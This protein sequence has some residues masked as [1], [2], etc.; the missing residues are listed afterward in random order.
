MG[1]LQAKRARISWAFAVAIHLIGFVGIARVARNVPM[2][3]FEN[4]PLRSEEAEIDIQWLAESPLPLPSLDRQSA[5]SARA[6][7]RSSVSPEAIGASPQIG[8]NGSTAASPNENSWSLNA[9]GDA[10]GS[11]NAP[12]S[13][14]ILPTDLLRRTAAADGVRAKDAARVDNAPIRKPDLK[15]EGISFALA[16]PLRTH[17]SSHMSDPDAPFQ[18]M[19]TL[20][21]VITRTGLSLSGVRSSTNDDEWEKWAREATKQFDT[22]SIRL[23]ER[24]DGLRVS[25]M[26]EAFERSYEGALVKDRPPTGPVLKGTGI[27]VSEKDG[28]QLAIELPSVTVGFQGKKCAGGATISAAGV[29]LGAGCDF[30]PPTRQTRVRIVEESVF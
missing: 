30:V 19:A 26:V 5:S 7:A 1:G 10:N 21:F 6:M 20:T 15:T 4:A 25:V 29:S 17:L 22:S 23:P 16:S 28:G 9:F 11:T 14:D 24:R 8:E 13:P 3:P 2:T 27:G 12:P 18:G